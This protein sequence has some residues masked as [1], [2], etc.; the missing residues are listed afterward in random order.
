MIRGTILT[1]RNIYQDGVEGEI[2]Y[3]VYVYI[4]GMLWV[5]ILVR[6]LE[7]FCDSNPTIEELI[8][9]SFVIKNRG[10]CFSFFLS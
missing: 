3:Q 5:A 10:F 1:E 2:P 4:L 9:L 8:R 7:E 6:I